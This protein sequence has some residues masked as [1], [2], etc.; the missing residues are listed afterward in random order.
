[1]QFKFVLH[2]ADHG[3]HAGVVR[4]R[5][6]FAE[7]HLV[8][9]HEQLHAEDTAPAE[10]VRDLLGYVACFLSAAGVIGCGCQD[11]T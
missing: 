8:V 9:L 2:L 4:A 6:D 3:D 10:I 11:S 7:P 1:M 5:A